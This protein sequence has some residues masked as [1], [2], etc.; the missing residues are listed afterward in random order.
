MQT[1]NTVLKHTQLGKGGGLCSM[2]QEGGREGWK[3]EREVV[4]AMNGKISF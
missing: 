2:V 1:L 3:V 4:R